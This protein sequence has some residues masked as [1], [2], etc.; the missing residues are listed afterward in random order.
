[1]YHLE[2]K[3]TGW[4]RTNILTTASDDVFEASSL[5]GTFHRLWLENQIADAL[6][7]NDKILDILWPTIL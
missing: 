1:M 4:C 5:L 6:G 3:E 7:K 2:K